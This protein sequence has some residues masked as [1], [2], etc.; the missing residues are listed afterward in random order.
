MTYA[1]LLKDIEA[2]IAHITSAHLS[3]DEKIALILTA[4]E[5]FS[6]AHLTYTDQLD[7]G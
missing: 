2:V 6:R 7:I 3:D 4:R 1:E 5:L